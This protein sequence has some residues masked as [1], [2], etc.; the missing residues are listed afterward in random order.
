[1]TASVAFYRETKACPF[2]AGFTIASL[3]HDIMMRAILNAITRL[4]IDSRQRDR[5]LCEDSNILV[6][7]GR[8]DRAY[9]IDLR[10]RLHPE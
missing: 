6:S 9:V 7:A 4:A 3:R 5:T 2:P 8:L 10:G 1:M